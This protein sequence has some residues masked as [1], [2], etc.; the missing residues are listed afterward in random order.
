MKFSNSKHSRA[1]P[2][3]CSRPR[4]LNVDQRADRDRAGSADSRTR[5]DRHRGCGVA[6][7]AHSPQTAC[8][9]GLA[10]E[11]REPSE[12]VWWTTQHRGRQHF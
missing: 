4:V 10:V 1:R 7:F 11:G 5:D 9:H 12:R 6:V 3:R 2:E 8:V